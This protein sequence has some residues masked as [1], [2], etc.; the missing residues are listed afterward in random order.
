MA[1][2]VTSTSVGIPTKYAKSF[3]YDVRDYIQP[4]AVQF[5]VAAGASSGGTWA[6][7]STQLVSFTGKQ[8]RSLTVVATTGSAAAAGADYWTGTLITNVAQ[9]FNNPPS[10]LVSPQGN[11]VSTFAGTFTGI[12]GYSIPAG[13]TGT[14]TSTGSSVYTFSGTGANTTGTSTTATDTGHAAFPAIGT[15]L[16]VYNPYVSVIDG[17]TCTVIC[18]GPGGTWTNTG[19]VFATGPNGGLGLSPGDVFIVAKGTDTSATYLGEAEFTYT[20]GTTFTV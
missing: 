5:S 8:L 2:P 9:N 7:L 10:V 6:G 1:A 18:R 16:P 4:E 15:N 14:Q 13:T 17:G 20:P 11:L 12:N 19:Y 3:A